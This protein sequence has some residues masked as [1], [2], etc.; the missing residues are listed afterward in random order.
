MT[1]ISPGKI[2]KQNV[3]WTDEKVAE[4]HAES[5]GNP[6]DYDLQDFL[7]LEHVT[8]Q[9]LL[10]VTLHESVLPEATLYNFAADCASRVYP[11][12]SH[13]DGRGMLLEAIEAARSGDQDRLAVARQSSHKAVRRLARSDL[14]KMMLRAAQAAR[15]CTKADPRDAAV[16]AAW[17]ATES[18]GEVDAEFVWQINHL[19]TLI[20]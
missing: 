1:R 7:K 14:P 11:H 20:A 12:I 4:R 3:C 15:G 5:P 10:W 8:P 13:I 18:V 9:D 17:R 16:T 6:A 2:L 19:R